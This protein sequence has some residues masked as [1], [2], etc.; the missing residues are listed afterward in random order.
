MNRYELKW[1]D[2]LDEKYNQYLNLRTWLIENEVDTDKCFHWQNTGAWYP[3]HI[4]LDTELAII[5]K[6][7]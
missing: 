6:L 2:A 4:D 3:S 5:L 7:K 1:S